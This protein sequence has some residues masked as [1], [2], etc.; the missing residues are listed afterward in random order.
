[1]SRSRRRAAAA[2]G[3]ARPLPDPL[4][5]LL[6]RLMPLGPVAARAMFGGYGI[7][8]DGVMFGIAAGE[9][10]Y[11]KIDDTTRGRY[12]EAGMAAFRPY[13]NHVVL[14]SYYEVPPAALAQGEALRDLAAKAHRVAA[15]A[16]LGRAART[17]AGRRR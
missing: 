14:R 9:R 12:V 15:R 8:L 4:A 1:V 10:F 5:A 6:A 16:A 11:F 13:G 3:P 2:R 17:R 7:Y